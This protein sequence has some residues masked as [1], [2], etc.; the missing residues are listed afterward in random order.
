MIGMVR[1]RDLKTGKP[2]IIVYRIEENNTLGFSIVIDGD[3]CI[4][5]PYTYSIHE[6]VRFGEQFIVRYSEIVRL[7]VKNKKEE[8]FKYLLDKMLTRHPPIH[9]SLS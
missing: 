7:D 6:G 8:L 1:D 3:K 5:T 4:V 2:M 9:S